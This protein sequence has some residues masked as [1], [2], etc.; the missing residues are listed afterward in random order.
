MTLNKN[1]SKG[2]FVGNQWVRKGSLFL[3]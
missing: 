1:G 3:V 2:K